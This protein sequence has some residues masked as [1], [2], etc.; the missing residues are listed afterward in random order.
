MKFRRPIDD[1]SLV[2]FDPDLNFV[3]LMKSSTLG[4]KAL[5]TFTQVYKGL[6]LPLFCS[7]M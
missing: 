2:L 4:L 5:D 1:L 3:R 7:G 6:G